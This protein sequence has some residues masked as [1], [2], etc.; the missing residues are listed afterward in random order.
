MGGQAVRSGA[1]SKDAVATLSSAALILGHSL[2]GCAQLCLFHSSGKG[3]TRCRRFV[4]LFLSKFLC[5]A[6]G[7]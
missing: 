1:R 3:T 4:H 7:A 5:N 2:F 6:E